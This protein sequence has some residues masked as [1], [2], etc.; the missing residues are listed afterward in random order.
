MTW[1]YSLAFC[2]WLQSLNASLFIKGY[3]AYA[4]F[5]S[6]HGLLVRIT[7][8]SAASIKSFIFWSIN[9]TLYFVGT[10]VGLILKNV[11]PDVEKSR[12]QYLFLRQP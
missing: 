10:N 7:D 1:L 9:P 3:S 2:Q 8:I 12:G 4:L 11:L 6:L 5:Y